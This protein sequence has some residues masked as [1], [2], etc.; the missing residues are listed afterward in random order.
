[1]YDKGLVLEVLTQIYQSYYC[2]V[3]IGLQGNQVF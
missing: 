3:V 1:M 2:W